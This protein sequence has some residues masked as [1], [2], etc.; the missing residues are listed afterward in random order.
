MENFVTRSKEVPSEQCFSTF[1]SSCGTFQILLIWGFS[2]NPVKK[3]AEPRLKNTATDYSKLKQLSTVGQQN[4]FKLIKI[5]KI[6]LI[7]N[8]SAILV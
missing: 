2:G 7:L 8:L 3:L 1:F 5:I 6:P 4:I